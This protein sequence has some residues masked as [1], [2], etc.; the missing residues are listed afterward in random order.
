MSLNSNYTPKGIP[1][2]GCY[3][4][5]LLPHAVVYEHEM[6]Y[7]MLCIYPPKARVNGFEKIYQD[8]KEK[9]GEALLPVYTL[10]PKGSVRSYFVLFVRK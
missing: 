8:V 9:L 1:V 6:F 5:N 2:Q 10:V 3:L 4:N 7:T